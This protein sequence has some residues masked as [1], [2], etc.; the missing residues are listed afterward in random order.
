MKSIWSTKFHKLWKSMIRLWG[1]GLKHNRR[2]NSFVCNEKN[3]P[4]GN[5]ESFFSICSSWE[6]KYSFRSSKINTC[7]ITL[8]VPV[9]GYETL[10]RP[11]C[12]CRVLKMSVKFFNSPL[13]DSFNWLRTKRRI[14]ITFYYSPS[15]T[16]RED[17]FELRGSNGFVKYSLVKR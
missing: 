3:K 17:W 7:H 10:R 9:S 11:L 5:E 6:R 12:S 15:C 4:N 1:K 14:S 16:P 2:R 8:Y 13:S